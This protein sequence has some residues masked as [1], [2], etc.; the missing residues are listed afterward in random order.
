MFSKP[1]HQGISRLLLATRR[2]LCGQKSEGPYGQPQWRLKHHINIVVAR[3]ENPGLL[4][5]GETSGLLRM[6]V[7]SREC[8]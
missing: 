5:H 2:L 3:L 1:M 7:E 6:R 8:A 4:P